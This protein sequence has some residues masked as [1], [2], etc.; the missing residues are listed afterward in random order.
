[1]KFEKAIAA[2]EIAAR[3]GASLIGDDTLFATGI[4]EIH[5]VEPGDIAFSDAKKYFE[6]TLQSAATVILLNEAA[7]CPPGKAILVLPDPFRAYNTLMEEHRPFVPL[8]HPIDHHA[9]IHASVVIEPGAIIA[10]DVEIGEGCYIGANAYIG[11]HSVIGKH[12]VIG[13]GAIIGSD[14]FY[15]KKHSDG[16]FE[17][18]RS[19]GRVLLHDHVDIGAGSTINK[20]VSGDTIIGEGTKIDCQVHIGHGAVIGKNCLFAAQ[21]GIGGKTIVED[22]VVLY[23][24]VGIAQAIEIGKGAVVLAKS[25]VSKSLEGG[26]TY[27]GIPAD[28]VRDKY[29]E[30]AA[31]RQLPALLHRMK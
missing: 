2:K 9:R 4:N 22:N 28:E 29:K 26:K 16:H 25:G 7:E 23:G 1:M 14:A 10:P 11:S 19:G 12:V 13:P 31:L 18:W 21:V 15:Y 20:G 17:K 24:Q 3:F 5:K 30:L 6:K 27:F 8:R